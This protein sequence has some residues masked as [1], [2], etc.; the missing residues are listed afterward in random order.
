MSKLPTKQECEAAFRL[1]WCDGGAPWDEHGKI[2][3]EDWWQEDV[4]A[5]VSA[6]LE[7]GA[8]AVLHKLYK[9]SPAEMAAEFH[10]TLGREETSE[11]RLTLHLEE[12]RELESALG[13]PDGQNTWGS[14]VPVLDRSNLAREL[15]DVVYLCYGT[16]WAMGINLEAALAEVHRANMSKLDPAVRT[17]RAD[18]KVLKPPEFVP[19]DM[20]RAI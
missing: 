7:A 10:E 6:R 1:R 20:S 12:H 15:A 16:A 13:R 14:I 8:M 2:A 3:F 11:H 5:S 19:P 18:G 4:S 17:E 9:S